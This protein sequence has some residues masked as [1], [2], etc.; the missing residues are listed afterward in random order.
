MNRGNKRFINGLTDSESDENCTNE[1]NFNRRK[2]RINVIYSSSESETELTQEVDNTNCEVKWSNNHFVPKIHRFNPKHSGITNQIR[3][4]SQIIDY[5][6]LFISDELVDIIVE[7][8]NYYLAQ[9]TNNN[10]NNQEQTTRNEMYCFLAISL[11]MTRNKKL[12]LKEYWS[13]D[14]F[15]RSDIFGKIMT[16]DRYFLLLRILHF[17][18]EP[19]CIGDRL[20]KIKRIFDIIRHSFNAAFVPYQELCI[21]ESLLLYKG[22]LSFKQ[23]I[24][25][26]K[27][28]FGIKSF[29]LCDCKTGFVQDIIIYTGASTVADSPIK[30]I[31]KSGA[32]V[33]QLLKT[34]LG[35][36]HTLYVDN[37]YSSPALFSLLFAN[38]TNACGTVTKRRQGMPKI[39]NKLERGELSFRSSENLL[40]LK[41]MDKREV[42][43]IST[44][45][46]ADVMTVSRHRGRQS[47][48]KPVCIVD[49]NNSMGIVDKVDMVISSVDS[50]RKTLKWY[51]K[52]FFHLIDICVW[53]AY[54]LYKHKR[55]ATISMANYQLQLIKQIC[56][57]Y[58]KDYINRQVRKNDYPMRLTERHFPSLFVS[59]RKNRSRR[60]VVCSK[61]DKRSESRYECK[62]CNVGLC[63][64]QCFKIYHTQLYY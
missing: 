59:K 38:R 32:I 41:W 10:T 35:K 16:R 11:L 7:E 31:G 64:N 1:N 48:Q 63:I 24:P 45:H 49:Y 47:V 27:N 43:M 18:H 57:K 14:D 21:D 29:I 30:G 13:T 53:N 61:N 42:Y 62:E 8:S 12:S 50:T 20:I 58:H 23:Y 33:L 28:R 36:G 56:D 54:C 22:R 6:Q 55:N 52:F 15:L 19:G 3:L 2:R 17:S 46:T 5:F 39:E 4:S 34:Y 26:K 40:V 25:K 60:C 37:F 51:R 9:K 44:M